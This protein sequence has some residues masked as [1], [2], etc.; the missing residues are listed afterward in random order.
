MKCSSNKQLKEKQTMLLRWLV[1]VAAVLSLNAQVNAQRRRQQRPQGS[2]QGRPQAQQVGGCSCVYLVECAPHLNEIQ[3]S[4]DLGGGVAGVCCPVSPAAIGAAGARVTTRGT[5][6]PA[7]VSASLPSLESAMTRQSFTAGLN[8][9]NTINQI[10]QNLMQS[11]IVL[12]RF[13]PA[14]QHLRF[15]IIDDGARA[16][17]RNAMAIIAASRQLVN[18]FSLTR[19]QASF[20]LRNMPVRGTSLESL[21]PQVP[22]CPNPNSKYR[23]ADGSC[24]NLANPIWG[25]SNT[26]NQRILPPTYDDGVFEPRSRAVDG[27]PLPNARRISSNVLLDVNQPDESYTSSLMVWAQFID[28]EFAHVPFPTMDNGEGIQ[29]CPNGTLVAPAFRHPRCLPIDLTG[30]PFYGPQGRTCMNF[31]RSMVAVGAGSE[32]VFGYAEQLNQLTHWIDGSVIYGS[33]A[34]QMRN[35]R[36]LRNGLMKISGNNLLPINSNQGGDCEARERGALCFTAG[37]SRVNEQ[38]SLTGLHTLWVRQHNRVAGELQKLNP[39]WS[40]EAVFQETRRIIIAQEQHIIFNE[41]LPIIIGK[42]FMKAF[43]LNTLSSGF[44]NDY[45]PGINPNMNNEFSAAAFRFGHTLVQGTLRL[46]KTNGGVDTIRLRDHFNSPHLIELENRLDDIV[47]SFT[48]LAIQKFDS[49]ITQDLSNH[50]F[51]T[52]RFNSGM[53]L[54]SLN[55]QRGRDHGIGTYNNFREICGLPRARTF[56][57]LTDQIN[58]ENVQK[59]AR[60]YKSVDDIDFFV[61]G[62]TERSVPGSLLGWTFLCV[63]G[64]QFARL[65]KADRYFYDLAGQPGSFNDSVATDP[66][67]L[68][69]QDHV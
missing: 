22:T 1:V 66:S 55:I 33:T 56:N 62:I 42:D 4:C 61:G 26:P 11:S 19:N 2:P 21:C 13:S 63:V 38:P 17:D 47:R 43:G 39:Q 45:N 16:M 25:K 31:V 59:L 37:D 6:P 10:E 64:D 18:D 53:D 20:G 29:C 50:L 48:Q 36:A 12:Q 14:G 23:T 5:F 8:F 65:K 34:D 35:L 41:W 68:L 58:P 44:S 9:A 57:D 40:D 60:V 27:A 32:C 51:Q 49:F 3:Q 54:M 28:H 46:F 15:F 69:G 7:S 67:F 30:D 24:N 52:P